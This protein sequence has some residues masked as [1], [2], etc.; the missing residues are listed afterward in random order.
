[1]GLLRLAICVRCTRPGQDDRQNRSV[2]PMPLM[3]GDKPWVDPKHSAW[4]KP[5]TRVTA[6]KYATVGDTRR[7]YD[8]YGNEFGQWLANLAEW[9]W[10]VTCT[11]SREK[12]SIGFSEPGVGAAR[13]C[14]RELI[15]R[16]EARSFA[17]VFE[18]QQDGVPHLHALLGGCAAID[19]GVASEHFYRNY[20]ISRWKIYQPGGAAPKYL[21]KYLQKELI[22]MYVGLEGP[23]VMD[24]FKVFTGGLTKRGT[25][26]F[27]WDPSLGGT[28]V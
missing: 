1:M 26:R 10:F 14:L 5:D 13:A 24:Q 2:N 25:P 18:L 12:V 20:G 22:E 27:Q 19:G 17:C 3:P 9:H 6:W 21:G 28:R 7:E 8:D 16:S 4:S 23:Y 15:V 11:L